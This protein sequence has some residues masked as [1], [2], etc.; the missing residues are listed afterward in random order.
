M[1]LFLMAMTRVPWCAWGISGRLHHAVGA[2]VASEDI[3][4]R[5]GT[6]ANVRMPCHPIS[7]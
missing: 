2:T 5:R 4:L 6:H 3:M 7:C 1:K